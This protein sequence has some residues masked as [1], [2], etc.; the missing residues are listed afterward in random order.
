MKHT[1]FKIR[2]VFFTEKEINVISCIINGRSAKFISILLNVSVNTVNYHIK[3]IMQK[4]GC[5]CK[6]QLIDFVE[7]SKK[8]PSIMNVYADLL[9]RIGQDSLKRWYK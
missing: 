4:S 3:H 6:D 5:H 7:C 1:V 8:Y 9:N 2:T